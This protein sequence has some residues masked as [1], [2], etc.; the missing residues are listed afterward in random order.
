MIF[1]SPSNHHN[2]KI[3]QVY[4][5]FWVKP[6]TVELF[7]N[8]VFNKA[9]FFRMNDIYACA[10]CP[11]MLTIDVLINYSKIENIISIDSNVNISIYPTEGFPRG[12]SKRT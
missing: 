3:N 7:S 5:L 8:F 11:K 2:F 9:I 12:T 4:R 1:N 10:D 6:F